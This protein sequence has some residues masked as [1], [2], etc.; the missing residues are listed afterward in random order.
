MRLA[1]RSLAAVSYLTCTAADC[2]GVGGPEL[3]PARAACFSFYDCAIAVKAEVFA[4]IAFGSSEIEAIDVEPPELL[5][6]TRAGTELVLRPTR[7]GEGVITVRLA[8]GESTATWV[9][10]G[11]LATTRV[12]LAGAPSRSPRIA[13]YRG[14]ALHVVAEHLDATGARLLGHGFEAWEITGGELR[15]VPPAQL[16]L[17]PS[18][19]RIVVSGDAPAISVLARPGST[20]LDIDVMPPG[21]TARLAI[22][23]TDANGARILLPP[24]RGIGLA[25]DASTTATITPFTADDRA[26]LGR[27]AVDRLATSSTAPAIATAEI[28][29]AGAIRIVAKSAGET[30]ISIRLDGHVVQIPVV[31]REP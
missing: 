3:V 5:E 10:V 22:E 31:V 21:S 14:G 17:V 1:L 28:D 16:T 19:E 20:P 15:E 13:L 6:V 4:T 8:S 11:A 7:I 2:C 9:A 25:R 29:P 30:E 26:I 27:P 18:L 23:V 24:G 12:T